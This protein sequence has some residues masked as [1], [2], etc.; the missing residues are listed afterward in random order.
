MSPTATPE[1]HTPNPSGDG[2]TGPFPEPPEAG[3]LTDRQVRVLLTSVLVAA[4]CGLLYEL[5]VGTLSSYLLGNSTLHFSLTIGGFMSAMGLGSLL[6]RRIT[7]DPLAWFVGV[8]LAVGAVG[9]GGAALLYAAF[10]YAPAVYH[11]AMAAIVLAIGILIGL[12]IPL[13]ARVLDRAGR[14]RRDTVANVLAVDYVGA[15]VAALAFPFILLPTLGILRTSFVTGAINLAVV[16]ACLWAFRRELRR[17]A[18]VRL[19]AVAGVLA[20]VLVGGASGAAWLAS[21]F[22][23]KLYRAPVVYTEQ[24]PYQRLVVTRSGRGADTDTRL[25]LNGALQ[26]ST[27]DEHR[28]H[29]MLVHPAM[30]LASNRERILVLGGGDGMA[31]RE[32]LKWPE[33]Q[34][35]MLVDL[36]PAVTDLAQTHEALVQ[37]NSGALADPRVTIRHEDAYGFIESG[38]DLF[39]VIVVDLPDPNHESLNKLYSRPFYAM[40][41][42][43]LSAGGMV[44]VQ[45]TSP[46]FAREAFWSIIATA[47][48]ADLH[49]VPFHVWVPSFGDWG[50]FLGS[51][52]E[53]RP[54]RLAFPETLALRFATEAQFEAAQLF[55]GDVSRVPAEVNTLDNPILLRYYEQGWAR[56]Q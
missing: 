47:E 12:E 39:D 8:E 35:I 23:A 7:G 30:A 38:T 52:Y 15:L 41:R 27:R 20:V 4:A 51:T 14:Q 55:D 37:A 5:I 43:R 28:Y 53:V 6:S 29:E 36:D 21:T 56:W 2:W 26:F 50:F 19:G 11:A 44:S 16:G 54:E 33:V 3:G 25:F 46:Y 40:L 48:A 45:S 1:L 10:T 17:R 13:V 31:A 18:R 34:Q 22:E 9:G 42:A 32:A 49:P 24:S